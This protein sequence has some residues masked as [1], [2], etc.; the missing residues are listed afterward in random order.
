MVKINN[1]ENQ[2]SIQIMISSYII[3]IVHCIHYYSFNGVIIPVLIEKDKMLSYYTVGLL[4]FAIPIY[5]FSHGWRTKERY[6]NN[7]QSHFSLHAKLLFPGVVYGIM[8]FLVKHFDKQESSPIPYGCISIIGKWSWLVSYHLGLMT[9]FMCHFLVAMI[10]YPIT[11]LM[12]KNFEGIDEY[13]DREYA[14]VSSSDLFT[15]IEEELI[16]NSQVQK[17]I[18][19]VQNYN[20]LQKSSGNK[21]PYIISNLLI[22]F[23]IINIFYYFSFEANLYILYTFFYS[24]IFLIYSLR[25]LNKE[26][27]I[28]GVCIFMN[29][30][31]TSLYVYVNSEISSSSQGHSKLFFTSFFLF[32]SYYFTGFTMAF[33]D[34]RSRVQRYYL[35]ILL[36]IP[37]IYSLISFPSQAIQFS[38]L[39]FPIS[40][41][42]G[43]NL[44]SIISSWIWIVFTTCLIYRYNGNQVFDRKTEFLM[45]DLPYILTTI[46]TI[47]SFVYERAAQITIKLNR[48]QM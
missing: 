22:Y 40:V 48:V 16:N 41:Q 27:N 37:I 4:N 42:N 6:V 23:F 35:D 31:Y 30:L 1:T 39:L 5:L 8:V 9:I 20:G 13:R 25:F 24:S 11:C 32:L 26:S 14:L 12:R 38:P 47:L 46:V 33:S 17:T 21:L 7:F 19:L 43:D 28:N 36:L 15:N 29:I 10:M 2:F 34:S 3:F 18:N 45:N 44:I